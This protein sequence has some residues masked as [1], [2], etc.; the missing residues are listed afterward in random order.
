VAEMNVLGPGVADLRTLGL[1]GS[2]P[3]LEGW[4]E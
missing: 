1:S 2:S 4:V 3:L